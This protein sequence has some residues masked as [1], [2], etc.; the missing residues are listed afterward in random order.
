MVKVK[1]S[2]RLTNGK[3][4]VPLGRTNAHVIAFNTSE[5]S[6]DFVQGDFNFQLLLRILLLLIL[7]NYFTIGSRNDCA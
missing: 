7:L 3:F 4:L 6:E 2:G 1:T 5:D